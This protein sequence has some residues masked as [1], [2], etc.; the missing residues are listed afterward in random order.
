MLEPLARSPAHPPARVDGSSTGRTRRFI[1]I[2]IYIYI[3]IY[4]HVYVYTSGTRAHAHAKGTSEVDE[5]MGKEI[6]LG[7]TEGMRREEG[8]RRKERE[9]RDGGRE[10]GRRDAPEGQ[11]GGRRDGL[12]QNQLVFTLTRPTQVDFY[13]D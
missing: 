8:G 13:V 10:G 4:A 7:G 1:Y 3:N 12:D 2:Y 9:R 6:G 5:W 11:E